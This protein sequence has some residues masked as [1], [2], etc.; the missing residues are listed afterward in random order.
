[1]LVFKM[2][3]SPSLNAKRIVET[4]IELLD[5]EGRQ[6]FS[7]RKLAKKFGVDPMAIYYHIPNRA[8]LMYQVIESVVGECELPNKFSVWQEDVRAICCAFRTLAHRHPGVIQ[9]YDIYNEWTVSEHRI[10]EAMYAALSNS[11]FSDAEVVRA[12]KLLLAYTE[13]FCEWELTDWI[14]PFTPEKRIELDDSL[15]QGD[16]PRSR[17]LIGH[18]TD[19]DPETE[20]YYGLDVIIGGLE[21]RFNATS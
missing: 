10:F 9:A 7:M 3:K 1:M 8:A 21:A 6:K 11:P 14:A 15:S 16:F 17:K 20:F 13:N 18:I 5:L 2:P 4:A 12:T 19:I